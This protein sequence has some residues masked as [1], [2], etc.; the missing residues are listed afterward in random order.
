[1]F[2]RGD[3]NAVASGVIAM[4][5]SARLR[6]SLISTGSRSMRRN[7]MPVSAAAGRNTSSTFVPL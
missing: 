1:V 6:V 2:D 7:T 3:A 5:V 4:Q